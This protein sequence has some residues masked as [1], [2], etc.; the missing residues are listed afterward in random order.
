MVGYPV[1]DYKK[2]SVG[3]EAGTVEYRQSLRLLQVYDTKFHIKDLVNARV[4][5]T[6]YDLVPGY[7]FM[8]KVS[9]YHKVQHCILANKNPDIARLFK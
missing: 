7:I 3:T 8:V 1:E 6:E 5:F 2:K 9:G 4:K